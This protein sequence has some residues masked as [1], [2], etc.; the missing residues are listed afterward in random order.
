M[1]SSSKIYCQVRNIS[2]PDLYFSQSD[3]NSDLI[4]VLQSI[5]KVEISADDG[6]ESMEVD[7]EIENVD[8]FGSITDN[9][10]TEN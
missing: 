10:D 1:P 5:P 9:H 4:D 6:F 2:H 3:D 8:C 7:V